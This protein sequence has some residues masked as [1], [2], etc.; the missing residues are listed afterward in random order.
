MLDIVTAALNV[1]AMGIEESIFYYGAHSLII[2]QICAAVRSQLR[3]TLEIKEVFDHPTV[4]G[5]A[6]LI[7][8]REFAAAEEVVS[9]PKAPRTRPIPLTYQQEQIWFLNKLAPNNRAYNSQFS[10]RFNGKLDKTI[11]ERCLNEIIRRHEVLRTTFEEEDGLPI[12]VI[13]EPWEVNLPETD[14]RHLPQD[15]REEEAERLIT[16]E[17]KICFD[18]AQLPLVRWRLYRLG[19]KDWIFLHIEHHFLHDGWEVMV[20]LRELQT[21]YAAFLEGRE[22]P[23]EELPI[24]YADFAVW[25]RKTLCGKRLEEKVRYWIDKIHD[26]PFVLNLHA[27]H[28]RP[29]VQ[30]FQGGFFRFDLDRDLY[31]WLRELSLRHNA[32][33][34]MTMYSAFAILLSRYSGQD[35]LL[36]GTGVANRCMKETETLMGMLVNAVPLRSDLS[37]NPL[38]AKFLERTRKTILEDATHHDTPFPSI[39]EGLKAGNK[40]GRNP[41]FQVIFGFHDS[42]VPVLDFAGTRGTIVE[43]HNLTAKV[44]M[45]LICIPRAEQHI[46]M[47]AS[48]PLD[49]DLTLIWEYNSDLFERETIEQMISHY[50]TLLRQIVLDPLKRVEDLVMISDAEKRKLLEFSVGER[51]QYPGEKTIQELFEEQ[52]RRHP[53]KTAVIHNGQ[54]LSYLELNSR[55]NRLA[56]QLRQRYQEKLGAPLEPGTYVGICVDR[57]IDMVVGTIAIL[58]AGGAYVPVAPEYPEKRFQFMLDDANIKVILSQT[59]VKDL[60]PWLWEGDCTVISIDA[61][62]A[63]GANQPQD[64]LQ[65]VNKS[66]DPAYVI[67]TSGSTGIPKGVCVSHRAVHSFVQSAAALHYSENDAIAQMANHAFDAA[68]FEIWGSLLTGAKMVIIDSDTVLNPDRLLK[69]MEE[70]GITVCF[71]TTALFNLL[72]ENKIEVLTRLK[73]IQFGGEMASSHCVRRVLS[74]KR[75]KTALIHVYGPTECT[76]FSTFCELTDKGAN[77]DIVPIG[78][79]LRNY[80]AYVLDE[81][82]RLVPLG[83]PGELYIG[84][85]SVATGYLNRE[86]LTENRFIPN[87]F[88]T[89]EDLKSGVNLRLYRTGDLVRWLPDG[90]LHI[91]GRTDFQ[92]KIRG[93][94]IE[95]EEVERVILKHPGVKQCV[96]IPWEGNLVAYWVPSDPSGV[97]SQSV[98][99]SF[100]ATHLPE[101]MIPSG[102]IEMER[103][104]LNRNAK[105]DRTR[106]PPHSLALLTARKGDYAAP[107]NETEKALAAIWQDLLRTEGIGVHDSFFELGGNSLLT[108]RMLCRVKQELGVDINLASMFSMP[109]IAAIASQ[110][111]KSGP[112]D[113]GGEDN[114]A[115][116]I[117]DAQ[118]DLP[119]GGYG[120][121]DRAGQP[122]HVLLTGVTGFLGFHLLDKFLSLTKATVHCLV[123][124]A[125]EDMVSAKFRDTLRFYGRQDLEGHPRIA[126]LRGELKKPALGLPAETTRELSDILDHICHCGAMVHHMFDYRTLRGENVQSTIELLKIAL[127]GRRKVFNYVSTLSVASRSDSE[128]RIVE[129]ELGERPISTNGYVLTKWASERILLHHAEK[130]LPLNIFRPGNIT[131]H[132]VT[133]VCTPGKNHALLLVKGCIEMK[134]APDWNRH[135]EMTPVDTLAEA[136]VRL[137]LNS[138]GPGI[139]NMNNPL[140]IGWAE[141]IEVLG[142]LGFD[143]E[144]VSVDEWRKRLERIDETNALFPLREVYLKER[145]DL[146]D[147]ES[148]VPAAQ[149]SSTTQEALRKLG[150]S[151][152]RDY[153]RY[154]PA[155]AGYLKNS[156]FLA[157]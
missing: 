49:E 77:R 59:A 2:A 60:A 124:G 153:A 72:A 21:L 27:D 43:R 115:L 128:G 9:I 37:D 41:I 112:G 119:L 104:E 57:G 3:L 24:Q 31:Q 73:S 117:K 135:I 12:Q 95:P 99:R 61:G 81:K 92:L 83:V 65:S 54:A 63:A 15:R 91:L 6:R 69:T 109:T 11:L 48:A 102:F 68:T 157:A 146:I 10:V 67:Y 39:V 139:F 66:S 96:V 35:R 74:Q 5:I 129:V 127:S 147:P 134:C 34:F 138:R 46:T 17:M 84:G 38:F 137:S 44:D 82:L 1:D 143:M 151:Y 25:Q 126:L 111:D 108:V 13:H 30:D 52:V 98:L 78:R 97:V 140:Q 130:G 47:G 100:L 131:G 42:A 120:T 28:P 86:E 144:M 156:G 7:S 85:D 148:H 75:D 90:T 16:G 136:I 149:D 103:F 114:L 121:D 62:E 110:I 18:F 45:N 55:A 53:D 122:Q 71:F 150:V 36:V 94:R 58:K 40:L 107:R 154:I 105:L 87:P 50:V 56:R 19:E 8:K 14:L 79:P 142:K 23:L 116:A 152:L 155:V 125:T 133:G 26:Y 76:T 106:L 29:D 4:A 101:Y 70:N 88:A 20:F 32:T 51:A 93:F 118:V 80:A 145:M 123:R 113:L 33:L 132:S 141:Y 22:S 89:E 64:D